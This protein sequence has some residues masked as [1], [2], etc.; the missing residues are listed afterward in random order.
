MKR[1][2]GVLIVGLSFGVAVAQAGPDQA[3]PRFAG[4]TI[5]EYAEAHHQNG[6]LT[7]ELRA[8]EAI[9]AAM[10]ELARRPQAIAQTEI[11]E[12]CLAVLVIDETTGAAE[13]IA[14]MA[15]F[16]AHCE[17]RQLAGD[18]DAWIAAGLAGPAEPR[19]R[20]K[21]GDVPF[22]IPRGLCEAGEPVQTFD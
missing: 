6:V 2:I 4:I 3:L 12:G 7:L 18:A 17:M 22:V 14:A 10:F 5:E 20:V 1:R 21:P 13:V 15:R 16:D 8:D 9:G 19:P 11:A